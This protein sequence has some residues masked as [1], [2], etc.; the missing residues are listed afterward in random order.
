[1]NEGDIVLIKQEK[2]NKLSAA[3]EPSPH[4]VD[5]VNGSMITA[6]KSNGKLITRNSSAFKK[7]P[8]EL[9]ED[10][11]GGLENEFEIGEE[12]VEEEVTPETV[13]EE[14]TP[15]TEKEEEIEP[16]ER[17]TRSGRISRKP[18]YLQDYISK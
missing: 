11:T 13:E 12:T 16:K 6:R 8:K 17:V 14:I 1:M 3:Y 18:R 7:I 10:H 4:V 5:K 9:A 2:K 15:E